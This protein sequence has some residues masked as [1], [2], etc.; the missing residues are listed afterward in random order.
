MLGASQRDFKVSK[1]HQGSLWNQI[2]LW[3]CD[4]DNDYDVTI[5]IMLLIVFKINELDRQRLIGKI[6]QVILFYDYFKIHVII[7][8]LI[9]DKLFL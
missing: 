5:N 2:L 9:I 7:M 6:K 8:L 1:S 4:D 3:S